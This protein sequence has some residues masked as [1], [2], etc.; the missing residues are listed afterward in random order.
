MKIEHLDHL[1][2][3]DL[4]QIMDDD[5]ERLSLLV[6]VEPSFRPKAVSPNEMKVDEEWWVKS[7]KREWSSLEV[8]PTRELD[9]PT[10]E[11]YDHDEKEAI[12]YGNEKVVEFNLDAADTPGPSV[13]I[14]DRPKRIKKPSSNVLS[15]YIVFKK[16]P[17]K[18]NGAFDVKKTL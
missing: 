15:P 7:S 6:P 17:R 2:N 11:P 9:D 4:S 14:V 13:E 8:N 1:Y 16:R 12:D 18:T 5:M 10:G 3:E